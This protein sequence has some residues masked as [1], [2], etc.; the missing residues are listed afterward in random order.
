[1][2]AKFL[3]RAGVDGQ[4]KI[5]KKRSKGERGEGRAGAEQKTCDDR[6]IK[7]RERRK[8]KRGCKFWL[9]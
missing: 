4:G 6:S 3:V 7:A 8:E 9:G 2:L 1:M 5:K